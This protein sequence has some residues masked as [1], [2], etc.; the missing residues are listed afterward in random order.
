M[1]QND[2]DRRI[3]QLEAE[4]LR[5]RGW[6]SVMYKD[7]LR[8]QHAVSKAMAGKRDEA[9]AIY[10]EVFENSEKFSGNGENE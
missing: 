2:T 6:I 7:M 4:S 10:R 9:N 8:L 3:E 1:D 5:L